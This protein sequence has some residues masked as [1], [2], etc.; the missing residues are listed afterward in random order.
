MGSMSCFFI[1]IVLIA[2]AFFPER[3]TRGMCACPWPGLDRPPTGRVKVAAK[4]EVP[5]RSAH[6][7]WPPAR[8]ACLN[9]GTV[10][11]VFTFFFL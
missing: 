1:H 3:F 11:S 8:G 10:R 4:R 9:V 2:P 5:M 7:A 6:R